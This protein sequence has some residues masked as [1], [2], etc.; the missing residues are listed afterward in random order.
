MI[1]RSA[2][3]WSTDFQ[4]GYAGSI[5]VARSICYALKVLVTGMIVDLD[6]NDFRHLDRDSCQIR[7]RKSRHICAEQLVSGVRVYGVFSW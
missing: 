3:G 6:L 4:A 5:P 2:R 1:C 7:A